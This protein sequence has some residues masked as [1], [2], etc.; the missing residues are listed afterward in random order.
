MIFTTNFGA[1]CGDWGL[2]IFTY[3]KIIESAKCISNGWIFLIED[4]L[5]A[6]FEFELIG[7]LGQKI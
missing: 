1:N 4:I 5:M 7:C 3:D 6:K 2:Y